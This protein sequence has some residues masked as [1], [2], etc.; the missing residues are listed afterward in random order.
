MSRVEIITGRGE[1]RRWSAEEKARLVAETYEPGAIITHV[2]RRHGVAESCLHLWRKQ[3]GIPGGV[4]NELIP[5]TLEATPVPTAEAP[6]SPAPSRALITFPDGTRLE[7]GAD[8]PASAL[9]ALI[10]AVTGRR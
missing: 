2:A 3:L 5:V 8:Y 10:T 9:K 6:P 1:R 7:V 4:P